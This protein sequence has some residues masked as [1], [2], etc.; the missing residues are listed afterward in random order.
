MTHDMIFYAVRTP[1][2]KGK[3][4]AACAASSLSIYWAAC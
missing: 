1:L 2:G 3:K 4:M